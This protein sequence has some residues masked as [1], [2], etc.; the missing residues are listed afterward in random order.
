MCVSFNRIRLS[1]TL[2][3]L[4]H[5]AS[6][7]SKFRNQFS[8]RELHGG[9]VEEPAVMG[10]AVVTFKNQHYS[11]LVYVLCQLYNNDC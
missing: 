1:V 7:H 6:C 5:V 10:R 3:G 8:K 4:N 9:L 2:Q 11:I